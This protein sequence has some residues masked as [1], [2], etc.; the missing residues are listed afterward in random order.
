M[1]I[2]CHNLFLDGGLTSAFHRFRNTT[3]KPQSQMFTNP[4]ENVTDTINAIGLQEG[5][6]QKIGPISE[7]KAKSSKASCGPWTQEEHLKFLEAM[8]LFGNNWPKVRSFIGT[9]VPTQI[10]SHA[11]KF[12]SH[13]RREEVK[14]AK[15]DPVRSNQIFVITKEYR[16]IT[17]PHPKPRCSNSQ[18]ES[19]KEHRNSTL[20]K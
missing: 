7:R 15:K 5:K 14:K 18:P 4:L 17:I 16:C 11:Q 8:A 19:E 13:I 2:R 3:D 20:S 12:Y 6:P 9:R 10:R 1:D